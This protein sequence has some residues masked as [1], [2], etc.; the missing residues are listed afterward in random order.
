[1]ASLEGAASQESVARQEGAVA[2]HISSRSLSERLRGCVQ[3]KVILV[4]INLVIVVNALVL[5]AG[6]YPDIQ[7]GH[8]DLLMGVDAACLYIFTLELLL[9]M[10]AHG[11]SFFSGEHKAWNIFDLCVVVVSY[12]ETTFILVRLLRLLRLI[13]V[14]PS[15]R[16]VTATLLRSVPSI[17]SIIIVLGLVYYIFAVICTSLFAATFPEYFGSLERSFFS[18]FQIM[19]MESWASAIARP[20]M[21][22][23]PYAWLVFVSYIVICT[24]IVLNLVV[25]VI[26]DSIS[27]IREARAGKKEECG[28]AES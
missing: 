2:Q 17:F 15:A 9:R 27:T 8:H 10:A 18:L 19:T 21:V 13:E 7:H 12:L 1:M 22:Q 16:L 4:C 24:F 23:H 6:T 28:E 3:S 26:V 14:I 25:G 20:V 5:G 11:R